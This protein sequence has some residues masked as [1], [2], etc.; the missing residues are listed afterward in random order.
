MNLSADFEKLLV[1]VKQEELVWFEEEFDQ[2]FTDKN[3]KFTK[4]DKKTANQILDNLTE[5][6]NM[7][8]NDHLIQIL[9][10]VLENIEKKYPGLV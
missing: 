1:D 4:V 6:I 7:L 8:K 9:A 3:G 5:N 2:L 10:R